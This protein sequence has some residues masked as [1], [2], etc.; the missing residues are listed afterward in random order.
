[1]KTPLAVAIASLTLAACATPAPTTTAAAPA[2]GS[3]Y[4]WKDRLETAS[5]KLVCNWE[6]SRDAACASNGVVTLQRSALS[7]DVRPAGM[8]STGQWLVAVGAR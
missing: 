2:S 5:D 3:Y 6:R 8:C 1:M 7:G 4:C